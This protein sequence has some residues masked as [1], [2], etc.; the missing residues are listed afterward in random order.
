[1]KN[2]RRTHYW[3]CNLG[4]L[5]ASVATLLAATAPPN[6]D[7]AGIEFFEKKIRPILAEHCYECHSHQAKKLKADLYLDSR[8]GLL[9]GGE[10]GVAIVLGEPDKSRLIEAIRYGN[11]DLQMPPKKRLPDS[12]VA[13]LVQWVKMGAPWPEEP[14]PKI[15]ELA[16]VISDME[17]NRREHWAWQP[18]REHNPPVTKNLDWPKNAIDQFILA[19]LESLGLRPAPQA[20]RRALIRRAYFDLIGLPPAVNEV[21]EFVADSSPD[22]FTKVVDRLLANPHYGERY[23]R[24]WLDVARYGE[25]QAHSF[26]PRLYPQGFRYRD[27]LVRALNSDIPYDHFI[28]EQIA[29]DLLNEPDKLGRL[30]ALGFFALGPVYYGDAKMFD[31]LDDRIDTLTRGFLGL[32]VACARC[33][34]HKFDPITQKDYYALAGVFSSTAYV[35]VPTVPD[36]VVK[37]YDQA[38]S[39]IT[40]KTQAID[41]F[42]QEEGTKLN[43]TL[44]GDIAK[45]MVAAWKLENQRKSKP[46]ASVDQVVKAEGLQSVVLD[47]WIKY[48]AA[49]SK[50]VRPHLSRWNEM[51]SEQDSKTDLSSDEKAT[52]QARKAADAFQIYVLSI[53]KLRSAL[54]ESYAAAQANASGSAKEKLAKPVLD[55]TLA[56][57]ND[58]IF[59]ADGVLI[60]PKNQVEKTLPA[61]SKSQVSKLRSE[62]DGLKKMAPPKYPVIHAL[63]EGTKIGNIPVLLRGNS[64]NLG[65]EAP[66]RFLSVLAGENAPVFK[67]GSG[68][69]ELA[70]AIANKNNPLT[71]RVMV[72]RIWQHHFGRGLVRTAS[73]F[74]KLGEAPT[75]PELLDYLSS[76]FIELGWSMKALHRMI[77]LSA[78]YQMSS[79]ADAH[80]LELD[81][82]NKFH[83]RMNRQRLEVEAW[84]DAML[85][86]SDKLDQTVG[87]PSIP[88]ASSENRRRTFYASV[89]RHD[90]DSLLRLF[91]FPDPNVTSDARTVTTVPLQQLFV[92]NSDFMIRQAK[93]LAAK[94]TS[95]SDEADEAR[96]NRAFLTVYGRPPN[97]HELK[98]GLGFL[99]ASKSNHEAGGHESGSGS[100]ESASDGNGLSRWEEYAQVLLSANEFMFVD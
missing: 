73:N 22:A 53:R 44:V 93:A 77:M 78:T 65:E 86:V 25:D 23:G 46:K 54:D 83:W 16:K 52:E 5:L 47:R 88:L 89:S 76:R 91:D 13:A 42:L 3:I 96:I 79:Q 28:K 26:Q 68:R 95:R 50:N 71:A 38:Q 84:R 12:A 40:A 85:A 62:L 7:V 35:E 9:Q 92:L 69:L 61:A 17:K 100:A 99:S 64:E 10:S 74:G 24:H 19:K 90:L 8:E 36:D 51:R 66:R 6:H 15:A 41:K 32:T 27:W 31:Q 20:D 58:E 1:M 81:P 11:S 48:L 87:G 75:H 98:L 37:A 39:A 43:E 80:N 4:G 14:K 30:P 33:H 70:N 94:L 82:E 67:S 55:K 18:I 2:S 21:E 29:A 45:Y 63:K 72:N 34:D 97:E 60:I 59:G 57:V 56:A 49:G